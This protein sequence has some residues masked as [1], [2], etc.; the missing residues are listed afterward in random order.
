M[1]T[2]IV[3]RVFYDSHLD[4][5]S[6]KFVVQKRFFLVFMWEDAMNYVYFDTLEAAKEFEKKVQ[7]TKGRMTVNRVVS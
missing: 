2:R 4:I 5:K 6:V 3:E 1:K 7:A